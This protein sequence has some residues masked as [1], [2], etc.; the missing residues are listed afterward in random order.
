MDPDPQVDARSRSGAFASSPTVAK[1]GVIFES[2]VFWVERVEVCDRDGATRLRDVVRHPGAVTVIPVLADGRLVLIRNHRFTLRRWMVEFCA[3]KLEA[4][5]DPQEAALRE[6]EEETG[7]RA[8]NIESLGGYY[9]SPGFCDEF[10]RIYRAT[11][12]TP[13][14]TRHEIGEEIE[15]FTATR[16]EIRAMIVDGTLE[17]GKSIAAFAKFELLFPEVTKR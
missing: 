15:I 4:G 11:D 6:L 8:A 5:E 1:T 13:V 10:M 2:R 16:E 12:L 7:Y 17:D 9:T 3:G 14:P